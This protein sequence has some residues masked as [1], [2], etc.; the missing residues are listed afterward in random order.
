MD[1][2]YLDNIKNVPI[3]D[4]AS[5]IG[6]HVVG[7]HSP[8]YATLKEHDSVRID[9]QKNCFWRN[10]NNHSGSIVDFA[11]EFSNCSSSKE[12]IYEIAGMYGIEREKEYTPTYSKPTVAT[13]SSSRPP[14]KAGEVEYPQKAGSS[15]KAWN[16]LLNDRKI[17]RS[18]LY[19][20]R[21]HG[22]FYQDT[23]NNCVFKTDKFACMRST[24]G[25]KFAIDAKGC[26]Y[27]EGFFFK[28]NADAHK[29]YV[30]EGVIDI[31]SVMSMKC[32]QN[33]RYTECAYLG[34]SGV[35][36]HDSIYYHL[37]N[38][39]NID[40]VSLCFDNDEAGRDTYKQVSEKLAN[41]YPHI[42]VETNFAPTGK[43]WN[44]HLINIS[45][46]KEEKQMSLDGFTNAI[47]ERKVNNPIEQRANNQRSMS[48]NKER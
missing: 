46:T 7:L 47:A 23:H 22:M 48:V 42:K 11:M 18:V 3:I 19:Y 37:D 16:Y 25:K 21:S 4:Y 15:S 27:N 29:M 20:F 17:E 5:R 14:R 28:G 36:K 44:E 10:S 38:D 2:S 39:L 24:G 12:A 31:M 13:D 40:T 8:K 33:E 26:D 9:M 45:A 6:L 34:L 35:G 1:N 43:D 32:K 30:C 41:S